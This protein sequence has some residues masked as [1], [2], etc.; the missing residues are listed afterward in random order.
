MDSCCRERLENRA[1]VTSTWCVDLLQFNVFPQ[2]NPQ[3]CDDVIAA[4]SNM[5]KSEQERLLDAIRIIEGV[6]D[7]VRVNVS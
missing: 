7:K 1:A 4:M 3:A 6:S 2:F 5:K